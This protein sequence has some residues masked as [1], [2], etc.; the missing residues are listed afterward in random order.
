MLRHSRGMDGLDLALAEAVENF[1]RKRPKTEALQARAAAVMP[2]GNTRT[3]LYTVPFP[4]RA[5]RAVGPTITDI[6]GHDYL[7]LLGEYSAGLYGHS[8]PRIRAAIAAAVDTGL[9]LGAHHCREVELAEAVTARFNLDLVR[10]TN[11][12]TEAN[13]MALAAARCHTGRG[14][15]MPM[16]GGYHGGTLHFSHGASP[17]NAPFDCVLGRFNGTDA[18]RALIDRNANDLA[19]VIV[20]PMLGGGCLPADAEFLSM[21]REETARRGIVLIF[22]EVMTSRL[23][24]G[25]LAE[26]Y[27][28]APDLKTLGKYVGGGM[29]FGAFGGRRAIMERFDPSRPGALPHAGTF[30]N[31]TLTMTVGHAAITEIFTPAA[32][33]ELNARGDRLRERFNE[34]FMR[35]QAP[36]RAA[37]IGSMMTL[38][39]LAGAITTPEDTERADRRI[40]QLLFLDLI[41]QGIYI[42]ERG[43][44]ALSLMVSDD[45]C[46]RLVGAVEH[47]IKNRR[48]LFG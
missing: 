45:D 34:A 13:M 39:P 2:G 22:D 29:S 47:F 26:H 38:H 20:E 27:G 12:G 4:I 30:N 28:I 6:D 31:N 23:A 14:K 35:Y 24:P 21:L 40:K 41:D 48:A 44:M 33:I 37:G 15:I 17:V 36:F 19:A 3:V 5:A 11:S 10:F 42:A 1:R 16:Q 25:G 46:D 18:T 43:F 9:N 7:D 32:C 8:H